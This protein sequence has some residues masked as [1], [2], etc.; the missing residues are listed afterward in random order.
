MND[1]R[2]ASVCVV[3]SG[4]H[5]PNDSDRLVVS[6]RQTTLLDVLTKSLPCHVF[7]DEGEPVPRVL[8]VKELP[9]RKDVGMT[10]QVRQRAEGVA[11]QLHLAPAFLVRQVGI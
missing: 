8:V 7:C 4:E 1:L 11:D 3:Q 10:G 2:L 5:I 6:E 9:N